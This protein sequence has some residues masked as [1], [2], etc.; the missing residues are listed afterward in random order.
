MLQHYDAPFELLLVNDNSED[1]TKHIMQWMSR[2]RPRLK[3][4]NIERKNKEGA[5]KKY[6]L[7]IGIREAKH[8]HLLLTDADCIPASYQWATQMASAY[9]PGIDIV[10][11]YG[12]YEKHPGFLNKVIR[13]ET[14]H[15]ALQ[16]LS[17]ALAGHPYMGVGRN[18]SYKKDLFLST[19]ALPPLVIYLAATMIF[20][21]VK[22]LTEL[23]RPL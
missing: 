13:F 2:D 23:T 3:L 10:L 19:K 18:L 4:I 1:D 9:Q 6:P 20:S 12:P 7:S 11:G 22:Q 5:G 8:G 15:A 17:Y 16:Y 14:F 21:L